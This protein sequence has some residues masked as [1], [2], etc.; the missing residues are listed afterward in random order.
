MSPVATE[1]LVQRGLS[2]NDGFLGGHSRP[3][4]P[5]MS[6]LVVLGP[7]GDI[8]AVQAKR[9][10]VELDEG[11]ASNRLGIIEWTLGRGEH[12]T[13]SAP[14]STCGHGSVSGCTSDIDT[15]GTT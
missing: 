9:T 5:G 14:G 10:D 6:R 3:T 11:V 15:G 7:P 13:H 4:T 1:P 2:Q 12:D 8:A